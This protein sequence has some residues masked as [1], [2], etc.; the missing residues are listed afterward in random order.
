[1]GDFGGELGWIHEC[2]LLGAW[3]ERTNQLGKIT[4]FLA[5]G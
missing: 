5:N 1:M 3:M 2:K 4:T